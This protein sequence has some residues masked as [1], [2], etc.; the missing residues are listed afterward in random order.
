MKISG[1]VG[2]HEKGQEKSR[3]KTQWYN[4]PKDWKEGSV[5]QRVKGRLGRVPGPDPASLVGFWPPSSEHHR[6]AL[7]TSP[8]HH[9]DSVQ[10]NERT[11]GRMNE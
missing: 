9:R 4:A 10:L 5:K 1:D 2:V 7:A 11:D 8:A 3:A 6:D